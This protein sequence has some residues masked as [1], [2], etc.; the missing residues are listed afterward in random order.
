M[1]DSVVGT[2]PREAIPLPSAGGPGSRSRGW[3]DR[4]PRRV[5]FFPD[6]EKTRGPKGRRTRHGKSH[7]APDKLPA[8]HRREVCRKLHRAPTTDSGTAGWSCARRAKDCEAPPRSAG[9]ASRKIQPGSRMLPH[10]YCELTTVS[11]GYL[12]DENSVLYRLR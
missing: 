4:H 5:Q 6:R 1:R 3:C 10:S 9:S 12:S 7:P 11:C 8:L 2:T